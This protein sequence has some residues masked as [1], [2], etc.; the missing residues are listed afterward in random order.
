M[1]RHTTTA[2][3]A[4][5]LLPLLA[6]M[7]TGQTTILRPV[8]FHDV[9]LNDPFFRPRIETNHRVTLAANL[10]KCEETGRIRNFAVTGGLVEGKHEGRRY[11]DSDLY[12]VLEGVAYTLRTVEDEAL[13]IRADEIIAQ[14]ASAQG[15][16]GYLNTYYTLVHPEERWQNIAHGHE[17][18]CGGHLIEAAI[19]YEQAT[20]KRQ[21]LDVAIGFADLIDAEFGPDGR[22]DPP[23]H[24]EL[25]LALFKLARATGEARYRELGEFFLVQRGSREG[26]KGFGAYNQDHLPIR[27]Q[28]IVRGHA[29]RA[30]YQFAGTADLYALT[31]DTTLLEALEAVWEDV[32]V[33]KMYVT[34]GIGNSAHNEGFTE[35]FEL[36][37]DT[38]YAETCAAIGMA[39]WNHRMWLATGDRKYAD[40]MELEVYNNVPAGVSLEGDRF[41]Y[42]NPL[43]SSGGHHRVPWFDC[44]CC[45]TNIA[46]FVPAMG[47]RIYATDEESLWVA[48]Y[49]ASEAT[50]RVGEQDVKVKLETGYPWT[51]AVKLTVEAAETIGVRLRIPQ[52]CRSLAPPTD[53]EGQPIPV[54][55]DPRE[56]WLCVHAGG[57]DPS[58]VNLVFGLA[59]RRVHADPRV[60]AN[61]GR[62]A[63]A[64]GPIV[65]AFE[66]VDHDGR[67]GDLHLPDESMLDTAWK[68][69]LLGGVAVVETDGFRLLERM[70]DGG[71]KVEPVRLRGVPYCTWDNRD[72]GE[73]VVWL[74]ESAGLAT[75]PGEA[76]AALGEGVRIT[77]SHC[78]GND[79]L[80]ALLDE[81]RPRS[82]GDH[83]IPRH[84]FWDHRGTREW[85]E[86]R[87]DEPREVQRAL[88][89]WFDDT[90]RGA[91][92]VPASWSLSYREGEVWKPV[93][94]A[95]NMKFGTELDRFN[96]VGF[97]G[98]R[99]IALR[100]DVELQAGWAGGLLEWRLE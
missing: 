49:V 77:A 79:T 36:P 80:D 42:V 28:R 96:E 40:V 2:L 72:A 84:T 95:G 48:L 13:E 98:V 89:Y 69:Q 61:R 73:M 37:N 93:E 43:E 25:E 67:V 23:G 35:P 20:G 22:L 3:L 66:A 6:P 4:G 9:E 30:M 94:I 1:K 12:K 92:R 26:R 54:E 88:V 59:V 71:M 64:R 17:L 5:S 24:Q 53:G 87:F 75:L 74:P 41:F 56:G 55:G 39:L 18:Y 14:I 8:P 63:L 31:G 10:D 21:L 33:G 62:V 11:N 29:V 19:A 46:R 85:V 34:G 50:A 100:L 15:E 68:E 51:G 16:D 45:P 97:R 7:S 27:E 81:R 78:Y 70:E 38:A 82:S 60:E 99:T 91:C 65:Y 32:T 47:E 76:G 58:E 90:G 83:S 44:S 86:M 52:W 57:A